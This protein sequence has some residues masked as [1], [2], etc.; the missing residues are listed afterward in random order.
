MGTSRFVG[1][2]HW[3]LDVDG[4]EG[5]ALHASA[6]NNRGISQTHDYKGLTVKITP[7]GKKFENH[8]EDLNAWISYL[9]NPDSPFSTEWKISVKSEIAHHPGKVMDAESYLKNLEK[10]RTFCTPGS[11]FSAGEILVGQR[12]KL[13]RGEVIT[14]GHVWGN[15]GADKIAQSLGIYSIEDGF[16]ERI[17]EADVTG[18]DHVVFGRDTDLYMSMGLIYDAMNS[19]DHPARK[20]ITE[21]LIA[22]LL[23]RRTQVMGDVWAFI[24]GEVPS[25]LQNTSHM[26]SWIMLLLFTLFVLR[27][28]IDPSTT[29][30]QKKKILNAL[31]E[32]IIH[33]IIYGDDHLFTVGGDTELKA[34]FN[35]HTF[36][37]FLHRYYRMELRDLKS[38]GT[39]LSIEKDSKRWGSRTY[40]FVLRRKVGAQM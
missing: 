4:I 8:I 29:P 26:D 14:I 22:N 10:G 12:M 39:F 11:R 2:M 40:G 23:C 33:I 38:N 19:T 15:G 6:G 31:I 27:R 34:W 18:L 17:N 32:R 21:Y 28:A 36:A 1:K 7:T 16:D 20:F 24:K 9:E 5:R 35:A 13:E 37:E 25:G 30:E 3:G